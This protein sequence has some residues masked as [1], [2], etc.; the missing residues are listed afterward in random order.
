[1]PETIITALIAAMVSVIGTSAG[2]MASARRNRAEALKLCSEAHATDIETMKGVVGALASEVKRLTEDLNREQAKRQQL[3]QRV[4][5]LYREL[6]AAKAEN[7]SLKRENESLSLRVRELERERSE[8]RC[9]VEKLRLE[10]DQVRLA[11]K[12]TRDGL[13]RLDDG[14]RGDRSDGT[15]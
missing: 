13:Y 15:G 12:E 11:N 7:L 6:T 14:E 1:M 4:E 2:I 9:E 3:E 10:I 8:L 5:E